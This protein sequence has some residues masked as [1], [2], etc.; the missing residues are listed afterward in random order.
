MQYF[1]LF[2]TSELYFNIKTYEISALK[3]SKTLPY[4]FSK[5]PLMINI[6]LI[7]VCSANGIIKCFA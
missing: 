1:L 2:L 6:E 3:L 5:A 7:I 4:L